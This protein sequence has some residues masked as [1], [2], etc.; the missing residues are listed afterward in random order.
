MDNFLVKEVLTPINF[1]PQ[2]GGSKNTV[3]NFPDENISR[4]RVRRRPHNKKKN[5]HKDEVTEKLILKN[6][7]VT[8]TYDCS[9]LLEHLTIK[10]I[11]TN[12]TSKFIRARN[13]RHK[14][15]KIYSFVTNVIPVVFSSVLYAQQQCSVT[16][17][18]ITKTIEQLHIIKQRCTQENNHVVKQNSI[19]T[20]IRNA[21]AKLKRNKTAA[22]NKKSNTEKKKTK[23][24]KSLIERKGNTFKECMK[25]E[26]VDAGLENG[27]LIQGVIRINPKD[28]KKA[29]VSNK[30]RLLQ[31][32]LVDSVEDR[33]G[34]LEGDEVVLQLKETKDGK[35]TAVVV[36]ISKMVS[37]FCIILNISSVQTLASA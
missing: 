15:I 27:T 3:H 12:N 11:L 26:E 24:K 9:L 36:C 20:V 2:C 30:D 13:T 18:T 16:V 23:N 32:Y 34:A 1:I 35:Q 31:D 29:Y 5:P 22:V 19:A 10:P 6:T 33:N 4:K 37:R 14:R 21:T 17:S 8:Y 28:S 25:K 7:V